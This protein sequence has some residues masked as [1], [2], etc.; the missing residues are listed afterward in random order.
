MSLIQAQSTD[1]FPGEQIYPVN[2]CRTSLNTFLWKSYLHPDIT[3]PWHRNA[4]FFHGN[5]NKQTKKGL[6]L[7]GK[8]K[9]ETLW[10]FKTTLH[11]PSTIFCYDYLWWLNSAWGRFC[12]IKH[13][14][15]HAGFLHGNAAEEHSFPIKWAVH[16]HTYFLSQELWKHLGFGVQH[17][18]V[19]R[20]LDYNLFAHSTFTNRYILFLKSSAIAF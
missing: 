18:F 17:C 1:G 10:I 20:H 5:W 14:V 19:P 8:I 12:N 3:H 2:Q 6:C 13:L 7:L 4:F 16:M 9:R 11:R 15:Q